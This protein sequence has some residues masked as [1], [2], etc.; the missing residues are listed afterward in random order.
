VIGQT[1]IPSGLA[2]IL[3]A[4]TPLFTVVVMAAAGEE[5]LIIRRVAGVIVGLIGVAEIMNS[6]KEKTA[7]SRANAVEGRNPAVPIKGVW[8]FWPEHGGD[9]EF[10]QGVG[11]TPVPV[12]KS[13]KTNPDRLPENG[14]H[15]QRY[16]FDQN[17]EYRIRGYYTGKEVY[18]PNSN[19][20]LP[21]FMLTGYEVADRSPGWLFRPDDR[22]DPTRITVYPR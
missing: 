1:T 7:V 14:P 17:Y 18:E 19:Q 16:A 2:S 6:K 22:Y 9:H 15:G 5:K 20:F 12:K 21:E 13:K 3:N 8:R 10:V 4:T 11:G